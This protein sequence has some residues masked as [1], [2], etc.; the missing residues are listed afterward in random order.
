MTKLVSM[1][2]LVMVLVPAGLFAQAPDTVVVPNDNN[3]GT[4]NNVIQG[5]TTSTGQRN[6]PN[7]VYKL[8]RGGFYQLNGAI[9]TQ[10]G[11]HIRIEG[12]PAPA[13]GTDPGMAV[14]VEGVVTGVYYYFTIDCY[15]DRLIGCIQPHPWPLAVG[16]PLTQVC[17]QHFPRVRG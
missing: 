1:L 8:V 17:P 4:I 13:S 11:T 10:P 9:T 14:I 3:V 5:D 12:E 2:L 7:R 6:N 15:G 16:V